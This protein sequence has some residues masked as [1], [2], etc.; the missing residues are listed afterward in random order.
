MAATL[1]FSSVNKYA[2]S[3]S[4]SSIFELQSRTFT[5]LITCFLLGPLALLNTWSFFWRSPAHLFFTYIV[6]LIPFCLVFDGYVSSFRTRTPEE[7]CELMKST[8]KFEGWTFWSGQQMHTFPVGH[9]SWIVCTR[10][11]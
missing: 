10:D 3:V 2:N 5:S 9:M 1:P 6:P 8:K 7:V 11:S 4:S